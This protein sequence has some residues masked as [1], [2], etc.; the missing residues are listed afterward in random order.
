[1]GSYKIAFHHAGE[2]ADPDQ[3]ALEPDPAAVRALEAATRRWLPEYEPHA[4]L[5]ETCFYDNTPDEDFIV[6]RV[7][8]VVIGAGTSGHG[9]KFGP[10]LGELLAD[11]ATN[12]RPRFDLELFSLQRPAAHASLQE[13]DAAQRPDS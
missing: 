3:A 9:F 5:V 1:L 2:I 8:R 11:I 4:T 10:I 13:A 6:D 7:G 12:A